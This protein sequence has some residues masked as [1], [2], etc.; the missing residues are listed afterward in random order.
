MACF[1]RCWPLLFVTAA[2]C[3][4]IWGVWSS[5]Q[6]H[7]QNNYTKPTS[8]QHPI[9]IPLPD[10]QGWIAIFS[11][12]L[13]FSTIALF[14]VTH[15]A[16]KA[17]KKSA[18]VSEKTLITTQRAF[19]FISGITPRLALILLVKPLVGYLKSNGKIRAILRQKTCSFA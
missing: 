1:R 19:V 3:G 16:A 13:A 4:A 5:A 10:S 17:A 18:D 2:L 15:T 8:N 14:T 12:V 7:N 6:H 9:E 11:C